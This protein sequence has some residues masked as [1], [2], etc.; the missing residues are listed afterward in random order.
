MP[1]YGHR[2][3]KDNGKKPDED[4]DQG[5]WMPYEFDQPVSGAPK[6][7]NRSNADEDRKFIAY[8]ISERLN[9]VRS[10]AWF[11]LSGHA[12]E[13]IDSVSAMQSSDNIYPDLA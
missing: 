1:G 3:P 11:R 6:N 5:N 4:Y 9:V 2:R 8:G 13:D 12:R 10:V 7:R